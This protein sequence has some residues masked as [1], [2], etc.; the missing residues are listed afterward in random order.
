MKKAWNQPRVPRLLRSRSLGS[1]GFEWRQIE[2]GTASNSGVKVEPN[3]L[4]TL[5]S[6]YDQVSKIKGCSEWASLT[7]DI[8]SAQPKD[9]ISYSQDSSATKTGISLIK[10]SPSIFRLDHEGISLPSLRNLQVFRVAT[11]SSRAFGS[12]WKG[13]SHL[14]RQWR[15][16]QNRSPHW[17]RVPSKVADTQS[18][19]LFSK[20]CE[21][22]TFPEW[23][24]RDLGKAFLRSLVY[25]RTFV[26]PNVAFFATATAFFP[27]HPDLI[28]LDS[29]LRDLSV[30]IRLGQRSAS[31]MKGKSGES[32]H[33][34]EHSHMTT[35]V[36]VGRREFPT[37]AD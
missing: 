15:S 10:Y 25:K 3:R 14:P 24:S 7:A 16:Q 9:H 31:Q 11:H 28:Q 2:I 19:N 35:A 21:I 4:L 36:W 27:P 6:D 32:T 8:T 30:R 12:E 5:L 23:E 26:V 22:T 34:R 33:I 1:I 17:E 13:W 37:N 20:F 29:A 18:P